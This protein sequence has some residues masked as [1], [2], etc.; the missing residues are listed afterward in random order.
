MSKDQERSFIARITCGTNLAFFKTKLDSDLLESNSH[1]SAFPPDI[2]TT[3]H[4]HPPTNKTP[5]SPNYNKTMVVHFQCYDDYYNIQ[6]LSETYYQKYF[7]KNSQ[8]ILAA[9]PAA[10]GDT[11]S[12]NLLNSNHEIITL[13]DLSG[14]QATIRLKARHAGIIRRTIWPA[15]V[16]SV[17]FTEK[18][19]D[20]ATFKL[21]IL[22]RHAVSPKSSTPYS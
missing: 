15:P 6:I 21:D 16:N 12:F 10:G 17:C 9:R 4:A 3:F 13:D 18:S 22:E 14:S 5:R 20:I 8:G 1:S 11:V 19:G 7:D 2:I